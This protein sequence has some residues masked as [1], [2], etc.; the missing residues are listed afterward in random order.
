[1]TNPHG[2][3]L[4]TTP[5]AAA[6]PIGNARARSATATAAFACTS[7][8]TAITAPTTPAG[9]AYVRIAAVVVRCFNFRM[10]IV[11][12]VDPEGCPP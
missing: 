6:K 11:A 2:F 8:R 1:M 10:A 12:S 9:T 7:I 3:T 5:A 4:A